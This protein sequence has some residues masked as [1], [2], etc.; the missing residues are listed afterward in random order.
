MGLDE[1]RPTDDRTGGD[2]P[3]AGSTEAAAVGRAGVADA[4][5]D[6]AFLA[7]SPTRVRILR[8]L[9]ASRRLDR[10]TLGDR[11]DVARTTLTR[12]LDPLADRGWIEAGD[13]TVYT[14]T[15]AGEA[16]LTDFERLSETVAVT[17]AFAP[18]LRAV[19]RSTFDLHP[20]HL[21]GADLVV[22]SPSD[23]YA[24]VN[25][26]VE[27]VAD[28]D[29]YR[30]LLPAVGLSAMESAMDGLAEGASQELV[31]EASVAETLRSKPAY[32]RRLADA[33]ENGELRLFVT[34]ETVPFFVGIYPTGVQIGVADENGKPQAL[35]ES[36]ADAV[37]SWAEQ[38][39]ATYRDGATALEVDAT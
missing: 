2:A 3:D 38:T 7:R 13:A 16:V 18:F 26:H 24:P 12:N 35:V 17:E 34:E 28:A 10:A 27:A 23:P 9:D 5:D 31:V 32:A 39:Y 4:V 30:A 11:L 14:I 37:R 1:T 20:R 33:P 25:R 22:A 29:R 8:E 19:P 36:D 6:V 21:A 15:L